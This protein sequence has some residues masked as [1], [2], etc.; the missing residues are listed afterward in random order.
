MDTIDSPQID[1]RVQELQ[2]QVEPYS[3][4]DN[5]KKTRLSFSLNLSSVYVYIA[6]PILVFIAILIIRPSFVKTEAVL[7]DGSTTVKNSF[8]KIAMWT[9]ILGIIF[10]LGLFGINYK[11]RK[12]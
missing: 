1:A 4:Y 8:K 11:I 10:D 5:T 3:Q 9:L 6:I 2:S 7:E 12:K